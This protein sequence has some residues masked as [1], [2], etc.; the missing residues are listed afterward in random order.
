MAASFIVYP[1][2]SLIDVFIKNNTI[3]NI[4]VLFIWLIPATLLLRKTMRVDDKSSNIIE[5]IIMSLMFLMHIFV[6]NLTVGIT[7]GMISLILIIVGIKFKYKSYS[8]MGYISLILT[9]FVQTLVF[10][11]KMPW[12]AYIL[13][14]GIILIILAAIRESK[15][16]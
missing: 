9:V 6:N 14:A 3:Q 5:I 8:I 16:K 12:W 10:W 7:L 4:L 11:S 1:L 15:K 2:G 13:I